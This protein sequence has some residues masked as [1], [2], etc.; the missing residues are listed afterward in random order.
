MTVS[1]TA[2]PVDG[3]SPALDPNEEQALPSIPWWGI[4]LLIA[5]TFG[6]GMA[7]IVPMAYSLAVRLDELAPGRTEVL[8]YILGTGSAA[9]LL[10]A[11]LTG[12]LSD[13]TRSRWGRRRPFTVIGLLIGIASVPVMALAPNVF[14]LALGWMLSTVGWGTSAGSIGN[15][16]ADRLPPHQRGKISGFT[17]LMMQLSP[18]V[19]ILLVAQVRDQTLLVF[20]V[21]AAIATVFVALFVTFAGDPDSRGQREHDRL[22]VAGLLKSYVFRPRDVPDF[23]WNWLGRF[24]FFLGLTLTTSFTVYFYAQR[25]ELAV[26]DVAGVMVLTSSLSIGT[27]V[28]GS[29]GGGWLS[30][31]TARRKPLTLAGAALFAVGCVIAAFAHDIVTLVLGTLVS[32]L[33]IALFSAVGQALVLDVLPERDTQAGRYMAITMFA[34]KIPG[35]LAPIAAP[36]LLVIGAGAQNFTALYLTAAGLAL[37]GGL[38]IA[39]K[40]RGI[41]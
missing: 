4:A 12:I 36:A 27:A 15:W 23:A 33:G 13:R 14:V 37:A 10:L 29:I 34:Q 21:P 39:L 40:V 9:T 20:A 2:A 3:L 25:L 5:A 31:K 30:D 35:V 8:G 32:S 17:G 18:V 41:R 26:P 16:Q 1:V 38:I 28:L 11:P 22:T 6:A 19:G 7:M 24:V